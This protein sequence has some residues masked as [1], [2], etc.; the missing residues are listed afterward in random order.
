MATAA[1]AI[2]FAEVKAQAAALAAKPYVPSPPPHEA[3][4]RMEYARWAQVRFRGAA[5]WGHGGRFQLEPTPPGYLYPEPVH[6]HLVDADGTREYA[7]DPD[8]F[9]WGA[10]RTPATWPR[11]VS[12][13]G[14]RLLYPLGGAD[15]QEVLRFQGSS[16][17]RAIGAG[18]WYGLSARA[19][20]V[21]TARAG[22]E[23]FPR[24]TTF[25]LE[26]PAA[27]DRH[28]RLYAL[29]DG[30]SVTGAYA[31]LVRPGRATTLEVRAALHLRRPVEN[32]GLAPLT[33]SFLQG[34][35]SERKLAPLRGEVHDSDGL[36]I[37][38]ADGTWVHRPL[39]NPP[40][41]FVYSFLT[42]APRGYGL[43]Q[44]DRDAEHYAAPGAFYDRRPCAWVAPA[45]AWPPGH[46][47]LLELPA[48]AESQDNIAASYVIEPPAP[49]TPLEL[50]YTLTW[51]AA[52]PPPAAPGLGRVLATHYGRQPQRS[53]Y[54]VDFSALPAPPAPGP[55]TAP[56]SVEALIDIGPGAR[57]ADHRVRPN[58]HTGGTRLEFELRRDTREPV[59][60]RAFLAADGIP[61]TETWDYVDLPAD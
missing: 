30:P 18:Q 14:F 35:S 38:L 10:V 54:R 3:L 24:F 4:G 56:P 20:G 9:D 31:F 11:G 53:R 17:L 48:A 47:E 1:H 19:L 6:L 49:G 45:G 39:E 44:R 8:L 60:L 32:L 36:T 61:L 52:E 12:F 51:Q 7:F 50:R 21:N 46:V 43:C 42:P 28:V 25:W 34:E 58:P 59:Q 26:R 37:H 5:P 41:P 16:Y 29:L 55:G 57:L 27:A 33:S 40:A 23:E 22:R 13:S 2:D 15:A